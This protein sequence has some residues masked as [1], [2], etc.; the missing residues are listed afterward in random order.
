MDPAEMIQELDPKPG[1]RE[2]N[3]PFAEFLAENRV[4]AVV[5]SA[6]SARSK[7]RCLHTLRGPSRTAS[8]LLMGHA[9]GKR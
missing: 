3:Q 2:Q 5:P 1:I 6:A 7:G 9:C 4:P 8:I